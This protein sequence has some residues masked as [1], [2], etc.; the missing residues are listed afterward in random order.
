MNG[1][2][3]GL[4]ASLALLSMAATAA[5]G[6]IRA[7][8]ED[9]R[10]VILSTDGHWAFDTRAN[11]TPIKPSGDSPFHSSVQ[12]FSVSFD[13]SQ[14]ILSPMGSNDVANKRMFRNRSRPLFVAVV[15]D[16]LPATTSALRNS[17]IASAKKNGGEVKVLVDETRSIKGKDI[18]YVRYFVNNDGTEFVFANLFYGDDRGNIQVACFTAQQLFFKY[19]DECQKFLDG[20][21]IE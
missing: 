5:T 4:L 9:G 8:T 17:I 7:M 15:S 21:N 6:D 13:T 14:W 11:S 18:G 20:L 1:F 2:R 19:Q 3:I 12:A 16:E 10:K